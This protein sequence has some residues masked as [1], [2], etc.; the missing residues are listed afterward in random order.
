VL[1]NTDRQPVLQLINL[2][3]GRYV[4]NL[5]VED[6]EGLV[7]SDPMSLIIHSR[8]F[9]YVVKLFIKLYVQYHTM[10]ICLNY[11][12]HLPEAFDYNWNKKKKISTIL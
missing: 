6:A 5:E 12:L 11:I 9:S 3:A 8:G 2:V 1:P 7:S 10:S 4:F